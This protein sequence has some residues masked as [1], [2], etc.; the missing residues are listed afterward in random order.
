MQLFRCIIFSGN[1]VLLYAVVVML[2][3]GR[4]ILLT[5]IFYPSFEFLLLK[6]HPTRQGNEL[7]FSRSLSLTLNFI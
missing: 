7:N 6:Y 5:F 4:E 2:V 1:F 3:I